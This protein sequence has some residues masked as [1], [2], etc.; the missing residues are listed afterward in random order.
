[1]ET[2]RRDVATLAEL[3]SIA[4]TGGLGIRRSLELAGAT[5]GGPMHDEVS[6]LLA[7]IRIDGSAVLA[8]AD[9]TA[10]PLYRTLG[11]AALSGAPLLEPIG[12]LTDQ[13]HRDQAA[14]EERQARRLPILMLFPLTLLILPGFVLLTVAPALLDTFGR[15]Q[16]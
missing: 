13:L 15:L 1:M 4:L 11:R 2:T 5:V 12:R 16:I 10:A 8:T 6:A 3:T 7:R 9:G 14:A